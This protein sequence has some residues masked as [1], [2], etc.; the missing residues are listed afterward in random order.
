MLLLIQLV[1]AIIASARG[2][3]IRPFVYLVVWGGYAFY[4][5]SNIATESQADSLAVVLIAGDYVLMLVFLVMA[6]IG[7]RKKPAEVVAA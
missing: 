3:G 7:K 4:R 6:I 5:G 1:L 2:F